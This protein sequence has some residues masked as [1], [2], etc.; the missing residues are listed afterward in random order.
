MPQNTFNIY[1]KCPTLLNI[2]NNYEFYYEQYFMLDIK[3]NLLEI[4]VI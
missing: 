2:V 1:M 4:I 3:N